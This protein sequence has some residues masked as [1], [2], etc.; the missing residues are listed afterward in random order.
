M[1]CTKNGVK[2][3][4]REAEQS[5]QLIPRLR[6]RGFISSPSYVLMAWCLLKYRMRLRDVVLS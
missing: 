6:I 3:P 5:L 2:R 1:L 4:G